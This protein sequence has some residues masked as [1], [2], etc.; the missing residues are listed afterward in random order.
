MS[1]PHAALLA[2]VAEI[3]Q[4]CPCGARPESLA[5]HPHVIGCPVAKLREAIAAL[6][7]ADRDVGGPNDRCPHCAN[8]GCVC[9]HRWGES[10]RCEA[11]DRTPADRAAAAPAP[12]GLVM[13]AKVDAI[14]GEQLVRAGFD[15]DAH[16][17]TRT[18]LRRVG[19]EIAYAAL[20]ARP[21]AAPALE[22]LEQRAKNHEGQ[23]RY[24]VEEISSITGVKHD[25]PADAISTVRALMTTA[26]DMKAALRARPALSDEVL[27]LAKEALRVMDDMDYA[28]GGRPG[29]RCC[30]CDMPVTDH[31]PECVREQLR[32]VLARQQETDR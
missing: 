3:E 1:D 11:K 4:H 5:T 19:R 2:L 12:E 9:S 30:A 10:C 25:S 17:V 26:E 20:R 24:M 6:A 16:A 23:W 22:G 13:V 29:W 15:G 28:G 31:A 21:E 18:E 8:I 27:R 14:V 32:A 7:P